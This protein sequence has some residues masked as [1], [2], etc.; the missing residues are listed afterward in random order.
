MMNEFLSL[1]CIIPTVLQSFQLSEETSKSYRMAKKPLPSSLNH[2]CFHSNKTELCKIFWLK[3]H[4]LPIY[5]LEHSNACAVIAIPV[6]SSTPPHK[7]QVISTQSISDHF[8]CTTSNVIYCIS[9][10]LCNK[11]YVGEAG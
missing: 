11:L 5:H 8:T 6:I 1:W 10:S 9:C 2:L 4:Y 3:A 7:Y